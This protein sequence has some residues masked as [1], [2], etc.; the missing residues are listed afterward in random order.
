MAKIFEIGIAENRR[1][2]IK[3]VDQIE[4]VRHAVRELNPKADILI[5]Q[6]CDLDLTHLFESNESLYSE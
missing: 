4:T 5:T 3:N 2:V 1:E 6:Q